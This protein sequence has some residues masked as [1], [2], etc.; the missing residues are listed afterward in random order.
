MNNHTTVHFLG[1]KKY[2]EKKYQRFFS[3]HNGI[4][5]YSL[6]RKESGDRLQLG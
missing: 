6:R 4:L 5:I 2:Y 1:G 3:N